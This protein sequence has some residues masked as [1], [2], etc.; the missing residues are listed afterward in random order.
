MKKLSIFLFALSLLS[1]GCVRKKTH[2]EAS[3]DSQVY[4]QGHPH[5]L[6][7]KLRAEGKWQHQQGELTG[8]STDTINPAN[9]DLEWQA[10]WYNG[11]R[12]FFTKDQLSGGYPYSATGIY[13][14]QLDNNYV[15][16]RVFQ[17][18]MNTPLPMHD[19]SGGYKAANCT[20]CTQMIC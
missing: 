14:R 16:G 18:I 15:D 9:I 10:G 13:S 11:Y 12:S 17:T 3:V 20:N 8:T 4:V 19:M 5:E 2:N 6:L 7:T 1:V